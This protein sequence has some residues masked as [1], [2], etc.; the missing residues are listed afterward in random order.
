[1]EPSSGWKQG[2][3]VRL[4]GSNPGDKSLHVSDSVHHLYN[5]D[6]NHG[7]LVDFTLKIKVDNPSDGL[8]PEPAMF[9]VLSKYFL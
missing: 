5:A 2:S 6:T 9:E 7:F 8:S 4:A 3:Q 1:M